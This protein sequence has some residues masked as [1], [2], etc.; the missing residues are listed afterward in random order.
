MKYA[1]LIIGLLAGTALGGSVVAATD[2]PVGGKLD[3]AQVKA[4]VR[5]VISEEP[6]LILESLQ[7]F[8]MDQQKQQ[9]ASANEVLKDAT[10]RDQ[11]FNDPNAASVGP[12]DAKKV[13]VEFFDYNCGACKFMFK[14]V[15]E[16]VNKDKTAR[17]IFHEYPIFG[18]SSEANS[19]IGIAVNRLYPDKYYDF[20]VKMMS[21]EGRAD[22][23]AAYGFAKDLG[24]DV[25][26]LKAEAAK[27]E[28]TD[29][30]ESNRELGQKLHIQGTPTLVI[31]EEIIPHA[32]AMDELEAKLNEGAAAPAPAADAPK[33]DAPKPDAA[34]LKADVK[35]EAKPEAKPEIKPEPLADAPIVDVPALDSP[36]ADAPKLDDK[37]TN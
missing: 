19:R 32:L 10:V 34:P 14:N 9:A 7:K 6:K 21:H 27:K 4:I 18:P 25:A 35:P 12:K 37:P 16:L 23:K 31:G 20:H 28:I 11:V 2:T 13:V 15:Q 29:V 1:Q 26:K 22:E 36:K 3:D 8:Q 30:L 33:A 17:V 24:F 5:Q